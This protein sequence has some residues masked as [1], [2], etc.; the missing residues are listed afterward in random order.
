M[1]KIIC[2]LRSGGE[3]EADHVINLFKLSKRYN[4]EIDFVCL[5]DIEINGID[6][7]PLINDFPGWWSKLELFRVFRNEPVLYFD[8]DTIIIG[9]VSSLFRDKLTMLKD[10]NDLD[11]FGSGVMSWCGDYSY[12]YNL[13]NENPEKYMMEY[14]I[15]GKW[16]DQGFIINHLKAQPDSFEFGELHSYK[17][18]CKN[19][20]PDGTKVIFFHGKPRPWDTELYKGI[21]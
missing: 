19:G 2:V 16:G 14:K 9:K 1:A 20:V 5:S 18:H 11:S 21:L 3:F 4:P 13:F 7:I 6:T 17:A 8:L 12:I 15:P 10:V